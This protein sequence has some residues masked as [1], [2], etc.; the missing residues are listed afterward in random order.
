MLENQEL[1][2][3]IFLVKESVKLVQAGTPVFDALE[4]VAKRMNM[5]GGEALK[6]VYRDVQEM[7]STDSGADPGE[8]ALTAVIASLTR[9][10]RRRQ[11]VK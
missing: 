6:S 9:E 2:D 3:A 11:L 5:V 8:G 10:G 7:N 4:Q 1:L